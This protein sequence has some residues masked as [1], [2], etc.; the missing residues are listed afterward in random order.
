MALVGIVVVGI[1][2][3]YVVE[4]DFV[5]SY[6]AVVDFAETLVA[7]DIAHDIEAVTPILVLAEAFAAVPVADLTVAQ[8]ATLVFLFVHHR[9]TIHFAVPKVEPAILV[10]LRSLHMI[11]KIA[12]C[13]LMMFHN[14]CMCSHSFL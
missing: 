12:C 10:A 14:F 2:A 6:M 11:Y 7:V 4:A 5:V 8:A 9:L 13:R 1:V 3:A